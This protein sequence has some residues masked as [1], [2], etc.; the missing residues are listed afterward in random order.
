MQTAVGELEIFDTNP[1]ASS[2]EQHTSPCCGSLCE[3]LRCNPGRA[4][5]KSDEPDSGSALQAERGFQLIVIMQL[6]M[7]SV[8]AAA[9]P[10][11]MFGGSSAGHSCGLECL[12]V[13][14]QRRNGTLLSLKYSEDLYS[15]TAQ[16]ESSVT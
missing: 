14:R 2:A 7:E 6:R 10:V 16:S 1:T 13:L 4:P 9:A 11:H 5:L 15:E 8:P 12:S 3:D